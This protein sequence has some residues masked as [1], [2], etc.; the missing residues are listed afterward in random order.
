M[1]GLAIGLVMVAVGSGGL[2][3]NATALVGSLYSKEDPKADAGFSIFYMGVNIGGLVGPLLTGL[4]HKHFGFHVAS[5]PPRW[6]WPWAWSSTGS[7]ARTCPSRCARSQ[8]A[9]DR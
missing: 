9:A 7:D 8:P 3:A 4:L 5:A 1:V 6:A 2:K